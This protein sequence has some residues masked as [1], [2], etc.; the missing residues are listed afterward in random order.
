MN[1]PANTPAEPDSTA[2]YI[3]L[4]LGNPGEERARNR[5]NIGA[6]C[7]NVLAKRLG[8]KLDETWGPARIAK[9]TLSDK[10]VVL[11][12]SRTYMNH[13]GEAAAVLLRRTDAPLSHLIVLHDELDL[14]LGRLRLRPRGSTAGHNG[15]RSLVQHINSQDFPRIRLGIGRPYEHTDRPDLSREQIEEDVIRWVLANFTPEEE[16][17]AQELRE[18]AADCVACLLTEGVAAAMNKFN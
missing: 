15:A 10:P 8:V 2:P 5:H 6:Q 3:V 7:V 4:G 18:R 14:P 9:A 12:R 1:Q 11:A 17:A 16:R 13:S